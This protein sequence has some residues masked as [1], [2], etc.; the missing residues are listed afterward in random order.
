MQKYFKLGKK[1]CYSALMKSARALTITDIK[2]SARSNHDNFFLKTNSQHLNSRP[3][4]FYK[5]FILYYHTRCF[6]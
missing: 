2:I 5:K 1:K 3:I 6:V 4:W